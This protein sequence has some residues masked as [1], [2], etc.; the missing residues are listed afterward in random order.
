MFTEEE[1]KQ[2]EVKCNKLEVDSLVICAF[3]KRFI[4]KLPEEYD[5]KEFAI[6]L[7]QLESYLGELDVIN[8]TLRKFSTEKIVQAGFE[9]LV[10]FKDA[11][12]FMHYE[13]ELEN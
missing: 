6:K 2:K 8:L 12:G 5:R 10:E 13:N 3:L 4:F 7:I 9:I 11:H 1:I